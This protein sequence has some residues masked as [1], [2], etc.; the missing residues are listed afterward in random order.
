[1]LRRSLGTRS[2]RRR[3]FTDRHQ[4]LFSTTDNAGHRL[5]N[6]TYQVIRK[7]G[8]NLTVRIVILRRSNV[9]A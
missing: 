6:F 3:L 1:M 5:R 9:S 7:N 8:M 4:S 2:I